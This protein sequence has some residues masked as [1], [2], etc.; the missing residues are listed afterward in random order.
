MTNIRK[1][2]V[3]DRAIIK[4]GVYMGDLV[5]IIGIAYIE[6]N[7]KKMLRYVVLLP[8][9]GTRYCSPSGLISLN[10]E[11]YNVKTSKPAAL[12]AGKTARSP[13]VGKGRGKTP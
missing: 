6:Q 5:T 1:F 13:G 8:E 7:N 11:R 10:D 2:S 12:G 9:D 4:N 3:G